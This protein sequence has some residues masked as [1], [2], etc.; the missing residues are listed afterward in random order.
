MQGKRKVDRRVKGN[1]YYLDL[2]KR[3]EEE[4][5]VYLKAKEIYEIKLEEYLSYDM[6][7]NKNEEK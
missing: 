3:L 2:I 4:V 6:E 1:N 7:K 5:K